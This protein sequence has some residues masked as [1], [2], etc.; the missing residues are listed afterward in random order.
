MT[1][2]FASVVA[3]LS[4]ERGVTGSEALKFDSKVFAM[5]VKGELVVKVS[6]ER[7]RELLEATHASAFD[8][9]HGRIMK[10]WVSIATHAELDWCELAREALAYARG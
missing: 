7:A 10:Q 3:A 5:G 6:G 1:R 9:G 2:D 4:K 8:P